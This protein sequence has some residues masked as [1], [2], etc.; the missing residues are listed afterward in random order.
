MAENP[1]YRRHLHRDPVKFSTGYP[2]AASSPDTGRMLPA[3]LALAAPSSI[4]AFAVLVAVL[5]ARRED[6][7]D[8]MHALGGFRHRTRVRRRS[9]SLPASALG[10]MIYSASTTE[11]N[12]A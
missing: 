3:A 9:A 2:F 10:G 1:A 7:P 11:D 8:L 12:E 5:R 6:L 4:L